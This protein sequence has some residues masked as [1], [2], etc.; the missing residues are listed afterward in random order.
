MKP[1]DSKPSMK[2]PLPPEVRQN[3]LDLR[4]SHSLREVAQLT[5]LPI[6]TVKTI[7]SR[8]GAFRDNTAL[9]L[10][11]TLPPIQP[12]T[13]TELAI[14]SLPPEKRVTGDNDLDA[15]LWLREVI[16]TG[17]PALIEKAMKAVKRI[18]TPLVE[19]EKRYTNHLVSMNPGNFFAGFGSLNF[20]DLEGLAKRS[21]EKLARQHEGSSRFGD[22]LFNTTPAERFCID[23]LAGVNLKKASGFFDEQE[24]GK[25]FKACP[26]LMPQTLSDCLYE[27]GYWQHLYSLRSAV[28][29][30]DPAPEAQARDWFIFGCLA[31]IRPRTK[32]EAIAVFH[33]LAKEECMDRRETKSILLNLLG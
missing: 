13:G 17:Q 20:A 28:D 19:L 16:K 33:Y 18:K 23:S 32:D 22:K 30:G 21:I 14:P 10:L 31:T 12:S 5:S 27:L 15:V 26:V 1:P 7:C 4:R 8:S 6:G 3:V 2:T 25:L 24:V 9:R 29:V 11:L